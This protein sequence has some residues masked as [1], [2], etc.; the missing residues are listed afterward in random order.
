[1]IVIICAKYR[2]NPS[3]TVDATER[4][5]F[6]K[7]RPNDLIYR[8]RSK[9]MVHDTPSHGSDHLCLIWKESIRNC[10]WYRADTACGTD[11]R[12]DGR[13]DRRT[14]GRSE[15]SIPPQQLR[16]I[17]KRFLQLRCIIRRF[18]E[19]GDL[20]IWRMTFKNNRAPLLCYFKLCA[21]F[22]SHW[23]IETGVTVWKRTIWVNSTIFRAVWPWNLTDDLEK[24]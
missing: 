19:P 21:A 17:I 16:C 14:D 9:V 1:M 2:K 20:E 7:S 15:T 4:T 23:W 3:R 12:T 10:R 8:S 5:R 24:Q 18:L 22:R 13:T 11:G 6:S